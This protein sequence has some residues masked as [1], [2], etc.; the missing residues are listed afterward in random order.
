MRWLVPVSGV[1][2]HGTRFEAH[3][4]V[5]SI[6]GDREETLDQCPSHS[7]TPGG[8]NRVHRLQLGVRLVELLEGPDPHELAVEPCAEERHGRVEQ[9]LKSQGMN[10]RVG[11]TLR[12]N[13]RCWSS[14]S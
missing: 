6:G 3:P 12:E 1:T 2:V 4:P 9:A 13:A 7:S 11:V 8:L 5:V 14:T 10:A